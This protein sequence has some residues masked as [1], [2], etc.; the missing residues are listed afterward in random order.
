MLQSFKNI[1]F[2]Q[3]G[4][5][6]S[7]RLVTDE[8]VESS[9]T[10]TENHICREPDFNAMVETC[11]ACPSDHPKDVIAEAG[12]KPF[13]HVVASR[14]LV[15]SLLQYHYLP[16][17]PRN[18]DQV[19]A[20]VDIRSGK[21]VAACVFAYPVLRSHLREQVFGILPPEML[22]RDFRQLVRWMVHPEYRQEKL[23]TDLLRWSISK[24]EQPVIE[25]INRSWV[26]VKAFEELGMVERSDGERHYY[27]RLKECRK[28]VDEIRHPPSQSEYTEGKPLHVYPRLWVLK[29]HQRGQAEL[30]FCQ[31]YQ[32]APLRS[33]AWHRMAYLVSDESAYTAETME[34]SA[35]LEELRDETLRKA[36][37]NRMTAG[38]PDAS[39]N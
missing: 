27:Y 28:R 38:L 26:P 23:G 5:V 34:K 21:I 13:R 31:P 3:E 9:A 11:P 25:A 19:F 12:T 10:P 16:Y 18:V 15:H 39:V 32:G 37:L 33:H 20:T 2:F 17:W 24:M 1:L 6:M 8:G 22:N 14:W 36:M 4:V 35:C 7:L 30:V 29:D